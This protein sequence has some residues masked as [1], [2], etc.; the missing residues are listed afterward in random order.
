MSFRDQRVSCQKIPEFG[1]GRKK[2]KKIGSETKG[3][4]EGEGGG[5]NPKG[6]SSR[7]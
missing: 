4:E 1:K 3:A 5:V 2:K 6:F 7:G